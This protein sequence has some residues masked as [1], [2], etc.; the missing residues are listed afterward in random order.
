M[1]A[2]TL[3]PALRLVG[4]RQ[5]YPIRL[6]LA[7]KTVLHGIDLELARGASLG[8]VGP[9]GSGK[10]TL[11]RVIAG[12]EG[13]DDG[14]LEVL[15]ASPSVAAV[16][17]RIGWL[18]EDLPFPREMR[19]DEALRLSAGL[20]GVPRRELRARVDGYL[21][22]VGLADARKV[23]LAKFSKGM[24]RRFGLAAALIHE[25]ELV[26]LDEPTAGL[27]APG[28]AVLEDLLGEAKRR[29]ASLVVASHLLT[30]IQAHCDRLVVLVD[31]RVG[32]A[33]APRELAPDGGAVELE[34]EGLDARGL[35][36][37]EGDA[38][39]RGGRVLGRFV[40]ARNLV[41]LYRRFRPPPP[42]EPR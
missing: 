6:G 14:T 12:V 8:L 11:L 34:V 33:G 21:E 38:R 1:D 3:G 29:G 28:F 22:R 25:P 10:S 26:L 37:L 27:D 9:N 40:S 5:S 42:G 41:E 2:S 7:R 15:G 13:Y 32:L 35:D 17:R 20:Y 39:A 31:G 16:R 4:L 36:G 19:A 24:A 18:A 30:D 23:A